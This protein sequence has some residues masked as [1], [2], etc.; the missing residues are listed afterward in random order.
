CHHP[1]PTTPY[2]LS[3]HDALPIYPVKQA[4]GLPHRR[5][6]SPVDQDEDKR[7][8]RG[9]PSDGPPHPDRTEL[10]GR[11]AQIS[12]RDRIGDGDRRDRSEEHT[13]ELSHVSISYA[14]FCL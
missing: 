14:V 11:V 3:L 2:T 10:P 8:A 1:P 13:S 12:E 6:M 5:D 7:P 4:A 9:D